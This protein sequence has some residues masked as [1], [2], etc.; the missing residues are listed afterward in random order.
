MRT[1]LRKKNLVNSV[2]GGEGGQVTID[3]SAKTSSKP[4]ENMEK[5]FRLTAFKPIWG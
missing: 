5:L 3:K 2:G 4:W 1:F